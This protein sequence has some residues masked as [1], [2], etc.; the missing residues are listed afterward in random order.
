VPAASPQRPTFHGDAGTLF[1]LHVKHFLLTV[2]T[3]GFYGFWGRSNVRQYLYAQTSLGGDRFTYSGTGGE[4]FRGWI[5]AVGLFMLGGA[6]AVIL[7][8][9]VNEILGTVVLYLGAMF[10]LFPIALLGSRNYRL[11]RTTWRGIRFSFRGN[12]SRFL[13]IFIPGLLLSIVT[14][15]LYFPVFHA[16]IRRYLVSRSYFG[17]APFSFSGEGRALFGPYLL[18]LVLFPFTLG[19]YSFWYGAWRDRYYWEHTSFGPLSFRSTITGGEVLRLTIENIL[20]LIVTLG[21][22]FAWVQARTIKFR[23]AHLLLVGQATLDDVVQD[24]QGA[25]TTGE[26]LSEMFELDLVGADFFGL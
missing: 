23:C 21:F 17:N 2:I 25:S 14:L 3:F 18:N 12:V 13:G 26:G 8:M 1:G 11:S 24:A 4:L 6:V 10:V 22:G 19:L 20:L 16:D 15:G 9:A 7:S 5:K